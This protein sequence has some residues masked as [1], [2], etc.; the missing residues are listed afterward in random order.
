MLDI[1]NNG[2]V[3][4]NIDCHTDLNKYSDKFET[5]FLKE[6][7]LSEEEFET[8]VSKIPLEISLLKYITINP[9]FKKQGLA[10]RE[11]L[12]LLERST[13]GVLLICEMREEWLMSWYESLGFNT[14]FYFKGLP[15]MLRL[16]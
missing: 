8:L 13:N 12:R 3:V 15:V 10:K 5:Y 4:G 1:H 9:E 14:L 16:K 11:V 6:I 7:G 2:V